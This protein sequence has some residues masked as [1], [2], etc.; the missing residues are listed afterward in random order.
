MPPSEEGF[1]IQRPDMC[2]WQACCI[3]L[4]SIDRNS[5]SKAQSNWFS[6]W[7]Y[8]EDKVKKYYMGLKRLTNTAA[9]QLKL[10]KRKS[11][12]S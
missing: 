11:N 12:N 1:R 7:G 9:L 5:K 2:S 3:D 8:T 10:N 6:W 4:M